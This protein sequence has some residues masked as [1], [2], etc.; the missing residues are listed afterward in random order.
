MSG[1]CSIGDTDIETAPASTMRSEMTDERIGRSM[2]KW[3]NTDRRLLLCRLAALGRLPAGAPC[4]SRGGRLGDLDGLPG[5]DSQGAVDHDPV[6]G[7]QPA[8]D[9]N[10]FLAGIV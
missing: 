1:Y 9:E 5:D 10:A 3:V 6:A 2:K 4:R 8:R 7:L